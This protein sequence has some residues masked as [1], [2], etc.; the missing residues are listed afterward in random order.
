MI[1][2]DEVMRVFIKEVENTSYGKIS[3]GIIRRGKH[4][5][6]EIDTHITMTKD[7][8]VVTSNQERETI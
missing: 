4:E 8:K 6:F 7:G 1:I 2:P 5:H 3:L